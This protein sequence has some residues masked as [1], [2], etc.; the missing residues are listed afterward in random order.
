[1]YSQ[2]K[3]GLN[4]HNMNKEVRVNIVKGSI[5]DYALNVTKLHDLTIEDLSKILSDISELILQSDTK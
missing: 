1:M 5:T 3:N 4:C 2:E